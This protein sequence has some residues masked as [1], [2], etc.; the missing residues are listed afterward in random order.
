MKIKNGIRVE[1][2]GWIYIS[3]KGGAYDRGFAIGSLVAPEIKEIF[4]MLKYYIYSSY[5]IKLNMMVSLVSYF[6]KPKIQ[7]NYPEFFEEIEGIYKGA[8]SKKVNVSLDDM[9]FLN[10]YFSLDYIYS[11]FSKLINNNVKLKNK[12]GNIFPSNS[13]NSSQEGG[14][15]KCTAFIAVGKYTKDGK[16][17][18]AHNTF[19]NFIDGQFCNIIIDVKPL[20]GN[21]MLFQTFPGSI[22]SGT[23]FFITS[24]GIIGTETTIGGFNQFELKDPICCRI[25]Q[26][27]QYANSLD[28][29][30]KI[31]KKNNSGDY[32]NSWLFGDTKTNEIMKIEL[33]LKYVN[34][35]RKKSGYFIGYNA[36]EDPR[37]RNLECVNTGYDDIRRHQGSRRVRLTELMEEYIGKLDVEIGKQILADHYDVYLKKINLCSRT[38]CSHY[39]LDDRAF[40][41]QSDRPKPYQPR[42]AVDGIVCD[43]EMAKRMAF[44]ARWGTSCG[45][46]F[47]KKKFCNENIQWKNQEP[48]LRDR[49]TQDWTEFTI[50]K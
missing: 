40:M 15:D 9:I 20:K 3:V 22:S 2:N 12:Y 50:T 7:E 49:L 47:D 46:P 34:V 24:N 14:K 21:R 29:C 36:P 35:E 43:T 48:Y 5:G 26:C 10:C 17:V 27:M 38:C 11:H 42:G 32:A 31:L 45:T 25:R 19:E 8:I 6:F 16:I 37:I 23:D 1:K 30:V 41:S 33:G 39:E 4:R 13:G 28:D 44:I 18:C